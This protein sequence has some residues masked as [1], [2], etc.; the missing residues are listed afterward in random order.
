MYL[1]SFSIRSKAL[2]LDKPFH[3]DYRSFGDCSLKQSQ[4]VKIAKPSFQLEKMSFAARPVLGQMPQVDPSGKPVQ[5]DNQG[6]FA[7]YW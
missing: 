4:V 3:V 2:V 7:K 5:P 1:L 6:F